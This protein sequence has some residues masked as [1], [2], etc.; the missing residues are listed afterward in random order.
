[1]VSEQQQENPAPEIVDNAVAEGG[2]Y[3]LIRKRLIE[4]G[5]TLSEKTKTLNEARTQEFGR[6]EMSVL[7]RVRVRTENNC[8]AR[9]IVQ[10]GGQLLFGYN[11]FIG[12]KKETRVEDVFALF[13]IH[14]ENGEYTMEAVP[15]EGTF[16]GE[17]A[18][19]NDFDE[20]YRY[21]K[22]TSLTELTIANGKLLA[23]FQIGERRDDIRVFRWALSPD[24]S[25]LEYIDNR[26]ERD[27]EMP[28]AYDF[29]WHATSREDTVHGRH[30]HVNILDTVFVETTG[31]DLTIKI[32]N[33]TEDGL[34]IYRES[35]DDDTQSI[36][37][38]SFSYA[39]V[40]D[41][42]LL[43][44]LP[45][46]ESNAR[47]FVYNRLT[48][49]VQR[50][51]QIGQS[52]VQLPEDHGIVFPG[53]YYLQTGEH[54]FFS[55]NPGSLQFKRSIR[56]P[57]GED[58][59]YV[60][61]DPYEGLSS[62]LTYSIIN[63]QS[64][65]PIQGHGYA[66]LPDGRLII[67]SAENE[68]T[69]VHPMQVWQT[70]YLSEVHAAGTASAQTFLGR[71][72]NADLVRGISDLYSICRFIEN[73]S[74]TSRVYEELGKTAKRVFDDHYW[75]Q[76]PELG[77][78][79]ALIQE[80]I[81]TAE[82]VIDEFEKVKSIRKQSAKAM[83]EAEEKTRQLLSRVQ[84]ESWETA[85]Q[86]VDMLGELRLQ[87][88]HLAT[89]K[90]YRY[91][92]LPRIEELDAQLQLG[93]ESLSEQTVRFLSDAKALDPYLARVAEID[94]SVASAQQSSDIDP[95][96]ESIE[97]MAE[98]LDLLSELMSTLKV[99][100]TNL[101]T[102]ILDAISVVYAKL[103]QT[104]A[105]ARHKRQDFGAEEAVAQF[106]AQFKL[107]A[108]S[109]ANALGLATTPEKCDEQ[110]G[111]L[112][113]LLEELESQFSDHDR[114]LSDIID[115]REE[116]YESF[117]SHKQLLLDERQRKAQS[118]GD[119]TERILRSIEK[120]AAK[121]TAA[122]EL[123]SYFA[124]DAL[125]LK[126][127]ELVAKLRELDSAVKADDYEAR[128]KGIKAQALRALRDKS[129]LYEADGNVIKL[130]P[131]HK[132]AVNNQELDITII[133][134]QG[135]LSVHITGTNYYEDV[136]SPELLAL[137]PYWEMGL[138]SESPQVYR[139]EYLASL[140]LRAVRDRGSALT[141][142]DLTAGLLD[143][144]ALLKL[145]R[146]FAG[147]LY[148]EGYEKGIHDHDALL[149]LKQL[150][151]AIRRA[152]L[153]AYDP[154]CRGL[155]QIFWANIEY[156]T[157]RPSASR[158]RE[159]GVLSHETWPE[160]AQS[161]LQMQSV[162][163]STEAV[164]LLVDEVREALTEFVAQ[165]PIPVTELDIHRGAGYLVAE[166]G[167]ERIEFIG[168]KYAA[169]LVERLRTHLDDDAW[170]RYES[171]LQKMQGWPAER[172]DLTTAWLQALVRETACEHLAA[173][174]PEAVAKINAEQRL[175]RRHSEVSL[176]L[177]ID[178]LLGE[179]PMIVDRSLKFSLDSF[180]KRLDHHHR[181]VVPGYREYLRLRQ[182][183][184]AE[185]RNE[186][187]LEEFRPRPL[188]SFVRN[189]LINESYL[190]LIGDNFAKQIGAAGE[191]KRTDLMGLLMMISP[192]GY[193]K[194]TLMEYVASRLGLIFMKINCPSL[195]RRVESLDPAMAP[196]A[197]ARQE[198]N[199]LNLA[200][201]MG[202]NV[203]LYLDDIQHTNPEF[204]QKF[205]SLCDGTR[206]I[207]GVWKG[208]TKAYD[209]RGRKF[210]VVMAGNPYTESG[211]TFKVPDM[212]ANRADIYNL[213][214]VLSG[215]QE[216]F[217]LS[218]IEN[219]LTSNAVLAPL[220]AREMADVY[221]LIDLA[222][223]KQVATSE[224]GHEYS[225]AEI[226]EITGVLKK[227]FEVQRVILKV[228]QQY[229]ASAAQNDKYRTEPP[230][231]LQ[232]SY[233]NM[234]KMTEKVSAV[235]NEAELQDL[236]SDHYLGEAQLL[237]TGTEDNL[238]KLAELR[239]T[240]SDEQAT[241]WE[242]IKKDYLRNKTLGGDEAD[243]GSRMVVQLADLVSGVQELS[244]IAAQAAK[245]EPVAPAK[246]DS[247]PLAEVLGQL[248]MLVEKNRPNIE[249]VNQPVPGMDKVLNVLAQTI[250]H[251]IFP[252]VRH[253]DKK[254]QI[255]LGTYEK[256]RD[257]SRQIENLGIELRQSAPPR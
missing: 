252:L 86:Y 78:I 26:G 84:P 51:D 144:A 161:A 90:D 97:H 229:I 106:G 11:V 101:R 196:D 16:L 233:R 125:V 67:F 158:E 186:L 134:R 66:L 246:N 167:R 28:P 142:D 112:L 137:K 35:V 136:D 65:N 95:L 52:C 132:F 157:K 227:M 80:I 152:D 70:P 55:D 176:E 145:I 13:R 154:L 183:V 99:Q 42:I 87:R 102:A 7:A 222:R 141:E 39:A 68:P 215:M 149:L 105:N 242:Q 253:M 20:L 175:D 180:L 174:I 85:E 40:G 73:Q 71:V 237:T 48:E 12:L 244:A 146:D 163:T 195:G 113:V 214:D 133:P 205:I 228:N 63:K 147:P 130:G 210:A 185:K 14:E 188:S 138:E 79:A 110:L 173:Y 58:I 165:H 166:L 159:N 225:G 47:Y 69:R 76:D 234:N 34:G 153:L 15:T 251:S 75:I 232:G 117:E 230:F 216:Q 226:S 123:N 107:F 139:A 171:S 207:D 19:V 53:G 124:S 108:Q 182:Q 49:T 140:I 245:T 164:E 88:G 249:V 81:A 191:G 172:W 156:R 248:I 114:F 25:V 238:L 201:E 170:R 94:K 236:V 204:L 224:L 127:R 168:S 83:L 254:L 202:N 208:Q 160:R 199:K 213:G 72:G 50:I 43:N 10:V 103:N 143:D 178:G 255:D 104:R 212:L 128:F 36:D 37:D 8:T 211:E 220:A 109:T 100:D 45:Y 219:A 17:T 148:K 135:E 5:R 41:L 179:H 29:E 187:R 54:K 184:V 93:I 247:E 243:V 189:R 98:G 192:P 241:R 240:M 120:R 197:T 162:F 250:E 116:I 203:L 31:G 177:E 217:A 91:I 57:N 64:Q 119:A 194:T 257:L 38:A 30:P 198:L 2:A 59:L 209:L 23:G 150:L 181:F 9:D 77:E 200:L 122:D 129:D 89:I 24:G 3:E 6:S 121:F 206:R 82:L 60:F 231:K 193:G 221:R 62:L 151:P 4:Q 61:Y 118:L 126:T 22:H 169:E 27:I 74:V 111:R 155:A 256:I 115:K 96:V 44:I 92:D 239:G 223:G 190:P 218:Y 1:M 46:R 33:N 21:Y 18:F 131:R 235:M 56:A 32:E